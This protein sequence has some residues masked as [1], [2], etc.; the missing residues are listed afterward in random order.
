MT[1]VRLKSLLALGLIC[2]TI[3]AFLC[4]FL[5]VKASDEAGGLI[6][7]QVVLIQDST[8]K[9]TAEEFRSHVMEYAQHNNI[10]IFL[11]ISDPNSPQTKRI[12]YIAPGSPTST[13]AQWLQDGYPTFSNDV[14][15]IVR[16]LSDYHVNDP[17]GFYYIDGPRGAG[18]NFFTMAKGYGMDGT[19]PQLNG[20]D[21]LRTESAALTIVVILVLLVAMSAIH[22]IIRSR[23]LAIATMIGQRTTT[24]VCREII[25]AFA[26]AWPI[27]AGLVAV[28]LGFLSWY[29]SFH[30]F[31]LLLSGFLILLSVYAIAM[32]V[33][34]WLTAKLLSITPLI[35]A[36]K[37][38]VP[39]KQL[40]WSAYVVRLGIVLF[41]CALS[42][43]LVPLMTQNSLRTKEIPLW[44]DR[45][46][47]TALFIAGSARDGY[48]DELGARLREMER[49]NKLILAYPRW[50]MGI[51]NSP[52]DLTQLLVNS[53]YAQRELHLPPGEPNVVRILYPADAPSADVDKAVEQVQ[54]QYSGLRVEKLPQPADFS[55]FSY[56]SESDAFSYDLML[57]RPV[58]TVLPPGLDMESDRNLS[59][60]STQRYVLLK[61]KAAAKELSEDPAFQGVIAGWR[62]AQDQWQEQTSKLAV[63]TRATAFNLGILLIVLAATVLACIITFSL[64]HRDRLR[65][66]LLIGV[67]F[68]RAYLGFLIAEAIFLVVPLGYLWYR[69]ASYHALLA[70]NPS[71]V[72]EFSR[73]MA[74]TPTIVALTIGLA[75][76]WLITAIWLAERRYTRAWHT[77]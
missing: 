24:F 15:M 30:R 20:F 7:N 68:T 62:P 2:A 67:P 64:R 8:G 16:H 33:T 65:A 39:G 21:Y 50:N 13:G 5:L 47:V 42:F 26:G 57:K 40:A 51:N 77:Q 34:C 31:G 56:Q 63:E 76:F 38:A 53:Y 75:A 1:W 6:G 9:T 29:N 70:S 49:Q 19:Q 71:M 73:S 52:E 59:A 36:I 74:V 11:T 12:L 17:R 18:Q 41:A 23:H 28:V 61:D 55:A 44:G 14:E 22:I 54:Q 46:D 69:N 60:W 4:S 35:A 43:S 25:N 3:F 27:I 10:D 72:A 37:G 48:A 58:V 66:C 32:G 45:S